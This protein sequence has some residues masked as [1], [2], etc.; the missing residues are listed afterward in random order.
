MHHRAKFCQN[1]L[2]RGRDMVIFPFFNMAAAAILD[3]LN[4]PIFN[5]QNGQECR[6][7][8][9]C[10]IWSKSV[11]TRLRYGVFSIFEDGGRRHLGFWK[12]QIPIDKAS[13]R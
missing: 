6:T 12:F 10:Q 9:A 1:T 4:F 5:C 2:N 8:P 7:T 11:K 13:R 3:F